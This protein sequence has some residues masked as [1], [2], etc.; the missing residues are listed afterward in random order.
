VLSAL[1]PIAPPE[2]R[3]GVKGKGIELR[4]H[5]PAPIDSYCN[6]QR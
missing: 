2:Y 1:W 4:E 5:N 3:G 6:R